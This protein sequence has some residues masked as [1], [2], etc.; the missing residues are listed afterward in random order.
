MSLGFSI[1]PRL[2]FQTKHYQQSKALDAQE[3][4]TKDLA[5]MIEQ[6][7]GSGELTHLQADDIYL[8]LSHLSNSDLKQII[9][10]GLNN[11]EHIDLMD[12]IYDEDIDSDHDHQKDL[13]RAIDLFHGFMRD[14][15][16]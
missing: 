2:W 4:T 10:R 16:Q 6:L 15:V 13:S 12:R 8:K 7:V 5:T 14:R 9:M 11:E 1:N 3:L